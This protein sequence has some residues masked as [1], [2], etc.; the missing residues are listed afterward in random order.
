MIAILLS[1][2]Y[3]LTNFYIGWRIFQWMNAC[4]H[5]FQNPFLRILLLLLYLTIATAPLTGFLIKKPRLLHRILKN[6]GNYFLGIFCYLLVTLVFL[7][8]A[9]LVLIF[10]IHLKFLDN[11]MVFILTG[12]FAAFFII[13]ISAY[14]IYQSKRLQITSYQITVTGKPHTKDSLKIVLLADLHLGYNSGTIHA[15]KIVQAINRLHPDLICIAGDIFDNEYE[16]LDSPGNLITVF[17]SLKAPCG[18][19]ACWGNH[20]I[21]EPILAGFTFSNR[22]NITA[23]PRMEEFLQKSRIRLLE[24][25]K[26]YLGDSFCLIGRKDEERTKKLKEK[27]LSP[28]ELLSETDKKMFLILMDHQPKDLQTLSSCGI[29]LHLSGHTHDGQMFPVNLI[30]RLSWKNSYGHLEI[31]NM[32]SIVTSGAGVW[33]PGIRVGTRSEI[34]SITVH[35]N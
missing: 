15:M 1:P 4:H 26:T 14:G 2:I 24:D 3:I 25:Q 33:G 31:G 10:G 20:D 8:L 6:I 29:D 16:A 23:D 17:Q 27:R 35:F 22:K 9:R 21:E 5:I 30:T 34:C 28:E 19:Y 12:A 32:H 13:T 11:R 18:I 7:D